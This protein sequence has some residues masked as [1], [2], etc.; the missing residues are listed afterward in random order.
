MH[1]VRPNATT[2]IVKGHIDGIHGT[3]SKE[4]VLIKHPR[5]YK[6]VR[7]SK[8]E[9]YVEIDGNTAP[10]I[11]SMFKEVAKGFE[12]AFVISV[13]NL[14]EKDIIYLKVHSLKCCVIN[15]T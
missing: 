13:K 3:L 4:N 14:Q 12:T 9:T 15:S 11:Q 10:F 6:N 7:I 8:H 1:I 2:S 5:G